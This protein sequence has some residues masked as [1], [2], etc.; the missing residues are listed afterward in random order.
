MT[1]DPLALPE[2]DRA[3][4]RLVRIVADLDG[5]AIG[6]PCLP[7][8]WNRGHVLTH[9][10]RNADSFVNLSTSARTSEDIPQYASSAAGTRTSRHHA[11]TQSEASR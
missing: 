3:T 7:P 8:G 5:T 9:L 2:V 6:E 10:V 4:G 1:L 11:P